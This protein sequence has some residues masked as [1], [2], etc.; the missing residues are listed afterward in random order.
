M[1]GNSQLSLLTHRQRHRRHEERENNEI[2]NRF[3]KLWLMSLVVPRLETINDSG[4]CATSPW[5]RRSSLVVHAHVVALV[6]GEATRAILTLMRILRPVS[7]SS[8]QQRPVLGR[9]I[10]RAVYRRS[11]TAAVEPLPVSAVTTED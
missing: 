8:S 11:H 9:V 10:S 7:C 3:D 4:G 6:G 5:R 2:I 1:Q